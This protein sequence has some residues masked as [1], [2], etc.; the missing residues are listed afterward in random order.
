VLAGLTLLWTAVRATR[1]AWI[2]RGVFASFQP[3]QPRAGAAFQASWPLPPRAATPWSERTTIRLRVAQYRIDDS[4]SST[5]ERLAEHFIQDARPTLN[6][7]GG[8]NLQARF[9]LPTDAPSQGARRSGEKVAWRLEWLDEEDS[10]LLAVP[11]PVQAAATRDD[12]ASDRL[13]RDALPV[14]HDIPLAASDGAMPSLPAGVH[15]QESPDALLLGF[16]QRGWRWTGIVALIALAFA[17][18]RSMVW[19]E[20]ALLTLALHAFSRHGRWRCGTTASCWSAL[21][22][23]GIVA[24]ARPLPA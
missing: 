23:S 9:E 17:C 2:Y 21:P 6:P 7:D 24:P 10:I 15:L 14:K 11:I 18:T 1:R 8:L 19:L 13:S 4:G 16:G 12:S 22:G 5:S 20:V 3:A